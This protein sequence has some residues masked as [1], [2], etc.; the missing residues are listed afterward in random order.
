MTASG[1]HEAKSSR[2]PSGAVACLGLHG[3]LVGKGGWG[4][5]GKPPT[6][7]LVCG[8]RKDEL[9]FLAGGEC[10]ELSVAVEAAVDLAEG[11]PRACLGRDL[12]LPE[13][14]LEPSKPRR[15]KHPSA[16]EHALHVTERKQGVRR[17][18]PRGYV[19]PDPLRLAA[20][21]GFW[22]ELTPNAA[23]SVPDWDRGN[24]N[25]GEGATGKSLPLMA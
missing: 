2:A 14:L 4:M 6:D 25:R 21:F 18:A 1:C 15:A 17:L 7:A 3:W 5:G 20:A 19:C 12:P 23:P 13:L 16:S 11:S 8:S 10:F 24:G 22:P 9:F